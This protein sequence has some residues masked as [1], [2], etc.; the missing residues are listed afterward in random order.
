MEYEVYVD[1]LETNIATLKEKCKTIRIKLKKTSKA[2][3]EEQS[4]TDKV[5]NEDKEQS[6]TDKNSVETTIKGEKSNRIPKT[7][8]IM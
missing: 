2:K 8:N 3:N 6:S 5:K 4:T 1:A 7:P